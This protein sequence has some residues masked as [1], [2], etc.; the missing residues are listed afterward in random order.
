MT[1]TIND[2]FGRLK[3]VDERTVISPLTFAKTLYTYGPDDKVAMITDAAGG[4][5]DV[6]P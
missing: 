2:S 6:V 3:E 4:D 1:K 5:H